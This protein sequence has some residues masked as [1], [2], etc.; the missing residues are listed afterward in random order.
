MAVAK[1]LDEAKRGRRFNRGNHDEH[2]GRTR[3]GAGTA[4]ET[5]RANARWQISAAQRRSDGVA[6]RRASQVWPRPT[7]A[8]TCASFSMSTWMSAL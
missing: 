5:A 1:R 3:T 6:A 8:R 2:G 7:S 4:R